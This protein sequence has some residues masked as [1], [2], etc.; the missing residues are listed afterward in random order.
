MEISCRPTLPRTRYRCVADFLTRE[1]DI[2][3]KIRTQISSLLQGSGAQWLLLE[4]KSLE[5][6]DVKDDRY[7]EYI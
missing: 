7:E 4:G 1:T 6:I 5:D 3:G 2:R